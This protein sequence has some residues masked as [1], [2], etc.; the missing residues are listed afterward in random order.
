MKDELKGRGYK[1][2]YHDHSAQGNSGIA[3]AM[4]PVGRLLKRY[5]PLRGEPTGCSCFEQQLFQAVGKKIVLKQVRIN[6]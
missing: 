6:G 5:Y 2:Q 3:T 4:S 1:V